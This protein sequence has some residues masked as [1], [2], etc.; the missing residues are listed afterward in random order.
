MTRPN[1]LF[2]LVDQLRAA[3][4]Q[5]YGETRIETPNIDRLAAEGT[6]F[7]NAVAPCPICGPARSIL[8]T[9]KLP[10]STGYVTSFLTHHADEVSLADCLNATDYRTA[11]IGKW[12]LVGGERSRII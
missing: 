8:L 7:D 11:W 5:V 1:I 10:P 12:H 9:G 4:L 3:A 6:I 2:I